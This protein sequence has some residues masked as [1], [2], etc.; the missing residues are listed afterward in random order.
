MIF[1]VVDLYIVLTN[2]PWFIINIFWLLIKEIISEF[3]QFISD[4]QRVHTYTYINYTTFL[5]AC[6]TVK[7]VLIHVYAN[8]LHTK[9]LVLGW[10]WY[11]K[12]VLEVQLN[13]PN[14]LLQNW[15]LRNLEHNKYPFTLL[16][17]AHQGL[18]CI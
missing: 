4:N 2:T 9:P 11:I 8:K 10:D 16:L 6:T 7:R 13:L 17:Y 12:T 14:L 3:T 5:H 1:S 15:S 18:L